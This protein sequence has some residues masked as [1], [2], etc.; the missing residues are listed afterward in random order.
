MM[1]SSVVVP[2]RNAASTIASCLQALVSQEGQEGGCEIIVVDDGST[3]ETS[4]IVKQFPAV[5]LIT[6]EHHGPASAR[7]LG[8][9]SA[10][11]NI[12]LFTDADCTPGPNWVSAMLTPFGVPQEEIAGAK[13]VYRTRQREIM[14]RFVQL[15]YEE[16]Y[17]RMSGTRTIDFVDTYSAAYRRDIFLSNGGFDEAFPSASVEDQDFSFR[18]SEKGFRMVFVPNAWVYHRHVTTVGAY[19]RRKF[20][21]G[22]WK[23]RVQRRHPGKT[24]QDSHTPTTL[25]LE[26]GFFLFATLGL[27][28]TPIIPTAWWLTFASLAALVLTS[29]PF[30]LFIVRRD[31]AVALVAPALIMARAAALAAGLAF[32]I[33]G[34]IGRSTRFKRAFDIAGASAGLVLSA[35]L[36][37]LIAIAIKLDSP[38]PI[39]FRQ[40]RA[41]QAGRPFTIIKFRSM[42]DGAEQML[43]GVIAQSL[44]P[45]PVFKIPNDPRVTRVGRVL[46]RF[47]LDEL[48]Q[49][50]NVLRGEMSL[51]GPRPE[52]LRIVSMYTPS[53]WRRL[54]A[55]PGM[56]GPMQTD[57]RGALSMDDRL[58]LEVAYIEEY[59]LWEDLRLLARTV[60]SVI[61]GRGAF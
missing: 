49:F 38:G 14:A 3:D 9:R 18:L 13:G 61:R 56:T 57:E 23:V 7:N 58:R 52:E 37:L 33:F 25:R 12:V 51:V 29:I 35:P 8:V 26:V 43:D 19:V 22:Y 36:M 31:R 27:L 1:R 34:E 50:I 20:R 47:S 41:G 11:G 30:L 59:N 48:P 46:R 39:I 60:P 54:A 5:R 2:A 44:V 42:V 28:L 4:E 24:L 53:Q 10:A 55:K 15:E 6:S 16:K 32:G 17:E 45:P 40:T 21:I